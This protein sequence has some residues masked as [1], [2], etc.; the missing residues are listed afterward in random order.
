[1][2]R[3]I[4]TFIF[5]C[6]TS[7]YVESSYTIAPELTFVFLSIYGVQSSMP[8]L[9]R[10]TRIQKNALPTTI[11][12]VLGGAA[13]HPHS[14]DFL[15]SPPFLASVVITQAVTA[16]SMVIND[17]YDVDVDRI[18]NPGRP[19][20]TGEVSL[21]AARA[22]TVGLF[23]GASATGHLVYSEPGSVLPIIVDGCIV[24]S[25]LYTPVW[26]RL[27]L[28]KN[29]AC[30]SIVAST[31]YFSGMASV[32]DLDPVSALNYVSAL[33]APTSFVFGT[34]C[35]LEIML[36]ISDTEGDRAHGIPTLPVVLGRDA[37]LVIASGILIL[38]TLV[39]ARM[40]V[41]CGHVS[42]IVAV[43]FAGGMLPPILV[44]LEGVRASGY[45]PAAL[46]GVM[47][48]TVWVLIA[49]GLAQRV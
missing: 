17:L 16:G 4:Y 49:Y 34:S 23:A 26:K 7:E 13:A 20:V 10:L 27:F 21:Q 33:E 29:L 5:L 46:K 30:A 45:A 41:L 19:L 32:Y 1:M 15:T 44:Q 24:M 28:V 2:Y 18:N 12:S 22:L 36:D 42:P 48:N 47:K 40:L 31:I 11:L 6:C 37:A 9:A 25:V 43:V 3:T 8:P 38:V 14:Y 35:F 39:T